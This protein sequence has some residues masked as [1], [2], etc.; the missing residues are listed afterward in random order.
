MRTTNG[1]EELRALQ[2]RETN[3]SLSALEAD[4]V[5]PPS[6]SMVRAIHRHGEVLRD[7][8][9]DFARTRVCS[10]SV[11]PI[12]LSYSTLQQNV[13]TALDRENLISGV[14]NDIE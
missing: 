5:N 11:L 14:R 6:Q 2:L 10:S 12:P 3:T 4:S 1:M 7:Y 8:E 13:K 9:R